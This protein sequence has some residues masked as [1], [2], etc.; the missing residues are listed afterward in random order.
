MILSDYKY[1]PKL[2]TVRFFA[3]LCVIIHHIENGKNILGLPNIFHMNIIRN[4]GAHSVTIFFMLSG[5]LITLLLLKENQKTGTVAMGKFYLRRILRI[6]PLYYFLI[7][8]SFFILPLFFSNQSFFGDAQD[9]GI[10]LV[11]YVCFLPVI[12]NNIF[13]ANRF[14]SQLWSIS[15]EEQFYLIWPLLV[16]KWIHKLAHMI[17]WFVGIKIVFQLLVY[18]ICFLMTKYTPDH[19]W[20]E[21]M[22]VFRKFMKVLYF[23][24]MA[25]GAMGA[26]LIFNRKEK[27]LSF[28]FK[29]VMEVGAMFLL[30]A[31]F[32]VNHSWPFIQVGVGIAGMI[33]ILNIVYNPLSKLPF[34]PR[35]TDQLGKYSYGMYMY[36]NIVLF[37][38]LTGMLKAGMKNIVGINALLYPATIILTIAV[39]Y[40]S[41]RFLEKPFL[42]LKDRAANV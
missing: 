41:Y 31:L 42:K 12:S 10:T 22:L 20:M 8:L 17:F 1:I 34:N 21:G 16:R 30:I 26:F 3:A 38:V 5:F 11:L 15:I 13:H 7:L 14:S 32:F 39:A 6:W 36:H 2:D 40:L 33:I 27:I 35:F 24:I 37:A 19:P 23:E 25:I 9:W 18:L 29:P 4:L 28:L